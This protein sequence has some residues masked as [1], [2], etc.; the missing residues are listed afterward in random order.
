MM[1]RTVS[2]LMAV[3]VLLAA[4]SAWG[5]PTRI[6]VKVRTKDAKFL[7]TSMGGALVTIRDADTGVLLAKGVTAGS[8]GNTERIMKKPRG[9]HQPLSDDASAKFTAT[10]DI[11]EPTRVEVS[12]FGP[13][14]QRQAANTVSL[15]QWLIPGRDIVQGD[16]LLL[17]MPG[18]AVDILAPAAH[19]RLADTELPL[20]L[21]IQANVVMMCGCPLT[22]GGIWDAAAYEVKALVKRDGIPYGELPL[23]Y[24]GTPSRF[25]APLEI[26][27]PG[28][29][30]IIVYAFDPV[31]GNT[32][33]DK[34]T[35][36]VE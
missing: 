24:A 12:A 3:A 6:T 36:V 35:V 18:F 20:R 34:T 1:K 11:D 31:S 27:K 33:V 4:L 19:A 17:E 14:A 28:S 25:G 26:A 16:A 13:L 10:I 15:T 21:E 2:L 5:M 7:G 23:T 30:E 29:Y 32:G 22:P 9:R 8:T